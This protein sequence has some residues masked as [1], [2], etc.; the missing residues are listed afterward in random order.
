M[1]D[2]REE[3]GRFLFRLKRQARAAERYSELR[4]KEKHTKGLLW[5]SKWQLKVDQT[6]RKDEKVRAHQIKV[7][8]VNSL[9]TSSDTQIDVLRTEQIA[10][11]SDMDS[12]QENFY[13]QY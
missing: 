12:I 3:I 9:K 7:E 13:R 5:S 2:L 1:E 4:E 10:K 11:Q 8:E 6:N